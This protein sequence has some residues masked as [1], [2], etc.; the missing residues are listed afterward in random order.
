[1]WHFD[2]MMQIYAEIFSSLHF[3][4]RAMLGARYSWRVGPCPF[5]AAFAYARRRLFKQIRSYAHGHNNS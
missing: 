5:A 1:M 4:R 2:A 3:G